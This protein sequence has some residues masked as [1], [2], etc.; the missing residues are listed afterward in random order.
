METQMATAKDFIEFWLENSVHADEQFGA[1]RG[2]TEIQHL[3]D[4]LLHAA[5]GQGFTQQQ[6][7]AEMGGDVN[8]F[9]RASIDRKNQ[10]EEGRLRKE[11]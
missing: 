4:N 3:A 1:R 7:E 5:E 10:A 6:I 2:R 9:I 8:D 11:T